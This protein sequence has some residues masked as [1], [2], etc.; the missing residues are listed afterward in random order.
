M[1]AYD[2]TLLS[3]YDTFHTN[4]D[5]DIATIQINKINKCYYLAI[6]EQITYKQH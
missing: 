1:Y 3:T 4:T 2:T 5:P 6:K